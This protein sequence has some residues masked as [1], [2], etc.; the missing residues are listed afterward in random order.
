MIMSG[1]VMHFKQHRFLM[2]SA[3]LVGFAACVAIYSLVNRQTTTELSYAQLHKRT[4]QIISTFENSTTTLQ[5]GYTEVL[6]D[7]RGITA[8][9]AGFTSGTGDLAEVVERYDSLQPDNGLSPYLMA[10]RDN[11]RSDSLAGLEG[12][13][14][15]WQQ[16]AKDPQLRAAQDNVYDEWYYEPALEQT[17]TAGISSA[18]G[19]LIILDTA[20]QHGNGDDPD[21]L[22]A[23]IRETTQKHGRPNPEDETQWLTAFL[24]IRRQHLFN[25]TDPSTRNAWRDSV[26]RTYALG[27]ILEQDT[28]LAGPLH[29]TVYGDKF[30]LPTIR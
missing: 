1:F 30:Q 5:Y 19:K 8:G 10:L 6:D 27:M 13:A 4:G 23:I 26:S 29:W 24:E 9:R 15:A 22:R 21:S 3:L 17:Q 20:V 18:A 14:A 28:T 12:F 11:N 16:A 25:A 2:V 7:G